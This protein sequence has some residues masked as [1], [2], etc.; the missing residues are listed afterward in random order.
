M[1]KTDSRRAELTTLWLVLMGVLLFCIGCVKQQVQ[2][3]TIIFSPEPWVIV[4]TALAAATASMTGWFVRRKRKWIGYLLLVG[5]I[6]VLGTAVPGLAISK[7]VIDADH[8]EW[9]RGF[10]H[11]SVRFDDLSEVVHSIKRVPIGRTTQDVHYFDFIKKDGEVVHVQAELSDR[12]FSDA[13][14]EILGRARVKGVTITEPPM[15]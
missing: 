11:T 10:K 3:D 9:W 13:T 14:P 1:S 8:F 4:V 7:T 12:F 2:G 15:E 6:L 5:G